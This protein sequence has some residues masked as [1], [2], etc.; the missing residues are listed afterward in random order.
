MED[1]LPNSCDMSNSVK[2]P[3]SYLSMEIHICLGSSVN[4]MFFLRKLWYL[5]EK[6]N[7]IFS[8]YDNTTYKIFYETPIDPETE[9]HILESSSKRGGPIL[10][11][12]LQVPP[13]Y[14]NER[15]MTQKANK[16][17]MDLL[18]YTPPIHHE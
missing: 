2:M 15:L 1:F 10:Y 9:F 7:Y 12:N 6:Y 13:L 16:Y 14:A 11:Y 17:I 8:L 3:L 18:V 5:R 4:Q